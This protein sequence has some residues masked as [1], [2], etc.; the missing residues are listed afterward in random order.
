M[1][2]EKPIPSFRWSAIT[3]PASPDFSASV[4]E[5]EEDVDNVTGQQPQTAP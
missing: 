3:Q 4:S 2:E 5:D 1:D